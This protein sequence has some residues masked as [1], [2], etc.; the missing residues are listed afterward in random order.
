MIIDRQDAV[1][2]QR[3]ALEADI[4]VEEVISYPASAIVENRPALATVRGSQGTT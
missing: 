2:L 4:A 3:N 1:D